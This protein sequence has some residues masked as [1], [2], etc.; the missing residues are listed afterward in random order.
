MMILRDFNL[1][2]LTK[3]YNIHIIFIIFL[4]YEGLIYFKIYYFLIIIHFIFN[5]VIMILIYILKINFTISLIHAIFGIFFY[6]TY[7]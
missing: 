4:N 3:F 7:S 1:K 6:P 2:F 5:F